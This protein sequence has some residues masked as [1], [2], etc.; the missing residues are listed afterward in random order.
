MK[1]I[2]RDMRLEELVRLELQLRTK[3]QKSKSA[4]VQ[5]ELREVEQAVRDKIWNK[6]GTQRKKEQMGGL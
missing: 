1:A 5:A 3:Y 6:G 2:Y 4:P